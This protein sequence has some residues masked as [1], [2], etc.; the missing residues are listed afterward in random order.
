[1]TIEEQPIPESINEEHL[2]PRP[3][4]EEQ[5]IPGPSW[6]IEHIQPAKLPALPV[7][8][9]LFPNANLAPKCQL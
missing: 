4:N 7:A 5:P 6:T 3:M 1:L 9:D 8:D 2:I